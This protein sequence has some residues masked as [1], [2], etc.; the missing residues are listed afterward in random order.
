LNLFDNE[1]GFRV[2]WGGKKCAE[3]GAMVVHLIDHYF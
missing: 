2:D 1:L 3:R